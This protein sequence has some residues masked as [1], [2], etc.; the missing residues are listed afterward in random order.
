MN[1]TPVIP[2]HRA[3]VN[4][5]AN[6]TDLAAQMVTACSHWRETIVQRGDAV[7]TPEA[8]ACKALLH[9]DADISFP[10]TVVFLFAFVGAICSP[11]MAFLGL[12]RLLELCRQAWGRVTAMYSG[13][14]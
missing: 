14:R 11:V 3:Q 6:V 4:P 1:E 8:A 13:A 7:G 9:P 2:P 12:L 5:P 10:M